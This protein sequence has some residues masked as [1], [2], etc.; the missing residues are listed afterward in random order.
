MIDPVQ[1]NIELLLDLRRLRIGASD[2]VTGA[3]AFDVLA[4][5]HS[6]AGRVAGTTP[7]EFRRRF[8]RLVPQIHVLSE[9]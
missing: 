1:P 7:A 8:S 5:F 3:R 6:N 9:G 4:Y 2:V